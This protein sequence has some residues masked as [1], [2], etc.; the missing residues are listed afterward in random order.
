[1]WISGYMSDNNNR[2]ELKTSNH[3]P[4]AVKMRHGERVY[5]HRSATNLILLLIITAVYCLFLWFLLTIT[6][7]RT[8][9]FMSINPKDQQEAMYLILAGILLL[10]ILIYKWG[11]FTFS[12]VRFTDSYL[13]AWNWR[14]KLTRIELDEIVAAN[15]RCI[16]RPR[17]WLNWKLSVCYK[18]NDKLYWIV[19]YSG[20]EGPARAL[21]HRIAHGIDLHEVE[22]KDELDTISITLDNLVWIRPGYEADIPPLKWWMRM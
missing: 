10:F 22:S 8:A 5:L 12:A 7:F 1:M 17:L 19:L 11:Q 14:G 4:F 16:N 21:K 18:A 13:S 3:S 9:Q 2:P 6:H 15:L 20:D